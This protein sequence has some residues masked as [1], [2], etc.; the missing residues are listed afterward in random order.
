VG[1]IGCGWVSNGHIGAWRKVRDATVVSVCDLFE[2]AARSMAKKWD[3][4]EYYMDFDELLSSS[5]VDVVDI[6]TPPSTHRDFM[7]QAMNA[8]VNAITEKPM[9]M[10]VN[11][12]QDI[13]DAKNETGMKAGVIHN[14]LF[15]PTIIEADSL[16]KE[17]EL[18]EIINVEVEAL[19]TKFDPMMSNKDHWCHKLVGGRISEMLPHLIY[20]VRRFL[21]P[22]ITVE[23]VQVSKVGDYSWMNS[24]ELCTI[25]RVGNKMGRAYASFNSPRDTIFVNIYGKEA[26]LKTDIVNAIL[27]LFPQRENNRF[28]KGIDS[29]RQAVQITGSTAKNVARIAT[30]TWDSGVDTIIKRFAESII[31]DE[32]PPVTVDEGLEVTKTLEKIA[33][34]IDK[35]EKERSLL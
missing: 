26:Y 22:E 30:K 28:S 27:T 14:W 12:S 25:F 10:T 19:N 7:V 23:S 24:D 4:D 29:I 3:I 21:G 35:S 8:G 34:M 18:G 2:D 32:D 31:M 1:V 15:E 11:E 6:C 13:V 33:F 17:G 20:L 5:G 16:V 9:T